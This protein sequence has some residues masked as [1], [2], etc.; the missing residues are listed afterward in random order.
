M[1]LF[2]YLSGFYPI[3]TMCLQSSAFLYNNEK[4]IS[5]RYTKAPTVDPSSSDEFS[6]MVVKKYADDLKNTQ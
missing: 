6:P 4:F 3:I 2:L 1:H 5:S